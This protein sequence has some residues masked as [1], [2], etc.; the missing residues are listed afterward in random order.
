MLNNADSIL[1]R[2]SSCG[3]L[4]VEPKEK[5]NLEKWQD[6]ISLCEK[7]K[8]E[9]E[10]IGN[11]D[12]KTAMKKYQS[13]LALQ[14]RI[15]ELYPIKDQVSLSEST[16][17]HLVDVFVSAKYGR[18]T[19][20]FSK[21]TT[22]GMQVEEDSITLYSRMT[23]KFYKKNEDRISNEFICGTP[24]LYEGKSIE[25]AEL[26][27]DVKS[28]WDIFT[29]FR[30]ANDSLNKRYYWQLQAYMALTGAKKAK[31]VYCLVNTPDVLIMDEKKK[32]MWKM[33]AGETDKDYQEACDEIDRLSIYDDV[34]MAERFF[35]VEIE[36]N[37]EDIARLYGK[38]ILCR[39]WMN[40]HLFKL[41]PHLIEN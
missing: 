25:E 19:D 21:Y 30:A 13:I 27:I 14:D 1:F 6:A 12:T 38:V 31:L 9:Y 8:Q 10:A 41:E 32:L 28:S 22:K 5:S 15:A 26:I 24:D 34:P 23:K 11:K 3:F 2:A 35:E 40:K 7:S 33:N 37:E 29:F 4:M 16:K 36:R 17:T 18:N 20:I 39:E